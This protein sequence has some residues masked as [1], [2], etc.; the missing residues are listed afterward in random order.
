MAYPAS[1][2]GGSDFSIQFTVVKPF[3]LL[4]QA[5]GHCSSWQPCWV[6]VFQCCTPTGAE[7][8]RCQGASLRPPSWPAV[9]QG[10]DPNLP[11]SRNT[12]VP[13]AY[14]LP[15]VPGSPREDFLG[16]RQERGL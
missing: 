14:G 9:E 2:T 10:P 6:G 15:K 13:G 16:G 8:Q 12:S 5:L 3:L 7:A 11:R 4:C 1:V